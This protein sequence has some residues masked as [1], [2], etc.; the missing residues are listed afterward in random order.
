MCDSKLGFSK[1]P[2]ESG[3]NILSPLQNDCTR[4]GKFTPHEEPHVLLLLINCFLLF[5]FAQKIDDFL[6]KGYS[7]GG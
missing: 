6:Q 2:V 4:G 1:R 5:M 7:I 3:A